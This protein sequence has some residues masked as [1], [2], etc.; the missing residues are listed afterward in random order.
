M[1][2]L[3][4]EHIPSDALTKGLPRAAHQRHTLVL[5]GISAL[6]WDQRVH[7]KI[8]ALPYADSAPIVTEP[9]NAEPIDSDDEP[10]N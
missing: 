3:P 1:R 9:T 8:D 2:Y 4:T 7:E 5:L 10:L 6:K